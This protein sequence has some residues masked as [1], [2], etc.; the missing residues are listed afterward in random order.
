M[1]ELAVSGVRK[2]Y[3][4]TVALEHAS[5]T[6]ADGKLLTLLGPSG[7]GKTTLLRIIAGITTAD[8][9]QVSI[10][11][12]R[13]DQLTPERRNIGMV[14][15]SYA[16]F[17]HMTV[18]DNVAF[19]LR[20]RGVKRMKA[21][22]RVGR[23]L[24][25]VDLA[26]YAERYPKQLS[27][28]Q[29]QRVALARALVIEPQVLLLD[30]P[31]SNLD[32]KLR[33]TLREDLRSLQQALGTTSIYVTHDQAEAMALADEIIVMNEGNIVE[34]GTPVSLYR[35]PKYRFTAAFLGH[36]NVIEAEVEGG[37]LKLP[38]GESH[39][40][41]VPAGKVTLSLRPEDLRLEHTQDNPNGVITVV[42]FLGAAV[43]YQVKLA[44]TVLRVQEAGRVEVLAEGTPVRVRLPQQVHVLQDNTPLPEEVLA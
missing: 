23:A 1:A 33:E 36:T 35:A 39:P 27:G 16:L 44:D 28:G 5:L 24:E 31:L 37:V 2:T 29:Q 40:L 30:E 41:K 42:T 18:F 9:G 12:C 17:P 6:A 25:L 10:D 11:N 38:W 22:Q 15:Q 8:T 20:M 7:C 43:Q 34:V 4:E 3:G 32:A 14:F 26:A 13:I 21:S 19:G